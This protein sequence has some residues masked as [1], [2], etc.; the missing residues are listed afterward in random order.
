MYSVAAHFG[1]DRPATAASVNA[2]RLHTTP[3]ETTRSAADG[4]RLWIAGL[5]I[6]PGRSLHQVLDSVLQGDLGHA[7]RTLTSLDGAFAGFLWDPP[8]RLVVV[9]DFAGLYPIY[10][11]RA[12]GE[13]SIAPTI[14]ELSDGTPDPAGWGA[15]LGFGHLV[16]ERTTSA[17][18]T[19]IPPATIIEYEA[20]SDR[21]ATRAYWQWPAAE[22][23]SLD[24]VD[25]GGIVD[26]IASSLAAYEPYGANG[27][28][29]L[30]GGFESRLLAALLTRAGRRPRALTLRNP[31]EH[32]EIE[33]RFAA[34]VARHLGLEHVL[35]DPDPDFFST[36]RYLEYV[37][38]HEV[39]SPSVNLFI[40]Q[41]CSELRDAGVEASWDGF[42]FG[43]ALK[44]K[45]AE[46]FDLFFKKVRRGPDS[47]VW[48]AAR[49]VFAP[50]FV[51]AMTDGLEAA[52]AREVA[53][54]HPG[55]HGT[56]QFFQRNRIR[57]RIAPNTLKVY[58]NFILPLLPG[59]TK[60][61]Y[62]RVLPIP[63]AVRAGEAVYF[64]IFERH[65]PELARVP[66]CSGGHLMPGTRN[67]L[68]YRALA[69]RSA[70]VEHPR[71]GR[72]LRRAGLA[73]SLPESAVVSR[74]V[75]DANL[76]DECL[77]AEG[78][79]GLQ[80]TAATG[81][82]EDTHAR[83]LVFYWS[84]WRDIMQPARVTHASA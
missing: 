81:T 60:D 2:R 29:L 84:M 49:Q 10:L 27:T 8:G 35:R 74:A 78:V 75:H 12:P 19:R 21:L 53:Q 39:A 34:R 67:D 51:D 31:Y 76:D 70:L 7:I 45:S 9:N 6:T 32:M 61:L 65:F 68:A 72:L 33:G 58:A 24:A 42:P 64:R 83:N 79:R 41:V 11:R 57:H 54:C 44:E 5:P 59:L 43:S 82:N 13:L 37:R 22:D 46:T 69:L 28:L 15:F 36:S 55:R 17:G 50:A 56:Q 62:S 40:A 80:R 25:T 52:V 16:G 66:W 20:G 63:A 14:A 1:K 71:A 38:L 23:I 26:A 48:H 30:S 3:V 77:N 18:V 47:A 73:P 4:R